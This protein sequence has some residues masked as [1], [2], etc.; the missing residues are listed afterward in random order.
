M[1]LAIEN[2][3][4]VAVVSHPSGV[5]VPEDLDSLIAQL[6]APLLINACEFDQTWPA[7][8]QTKATELLG[9]NYKPGFKQNYYAGCRH[10]FATRGNPSVE[11]EKIGKEGAA[12]EAVEWFKK[13]L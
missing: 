9:S 13:Y 1:D 4:D 2:S 6:K 11:L 8:F 12:R 3:L 10:G 7:E 5:K